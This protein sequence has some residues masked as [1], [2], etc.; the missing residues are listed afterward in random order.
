MFYVAEIF[1][2]AEKI[3][4]QQFV[5]SVFEQM[6]AAGNEKATKK[7]AKAAVDAVTSAIA[8]ELTSGNA[9]WFQ[10]LGTF[11]PK[12]RPARMG[13]SPRDGKPIEIP[14]A[15]VVNFKMGQSLKD[16]LNGKK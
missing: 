14:E 4:M 13:H 12:V 15:K 3:S 5:D 8:K 10:N 7:E 16:A 9:V 6:K 1:I 11:E 2:M